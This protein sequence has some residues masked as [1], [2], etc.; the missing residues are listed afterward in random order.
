MAWG[1]VHVIAGT[2]IYALA[3]MRSGG[4]PSAA[5]LVPAVIL[6]GMT[7]WPLDA[8]N[9]GPATIYHGTGDGGW[10]TASVIALR[11]IIWLTLI[12]FFTRHPR[13][14]FCALP[15]WLILD[16]EWFYNIQNGYGLHYNRMWPQWLTME[17]GLIPWTVALGLFL[18]MMVQPSLSEVR[19]RAAASIFVVKSSVQKAA[20][21]AGAGVQLS[22][23]KLISWAAV[24]NYLG[25]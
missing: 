25:R 5:T 16:H 6:S 13:A 18:W 15:A 11:V 7:H 12:W 24:R 20:S 2:S 9:F 10:I 3:Y 8:V 17:W 4:K 22:M 21:W 19:A 1:E 23:S 14:L